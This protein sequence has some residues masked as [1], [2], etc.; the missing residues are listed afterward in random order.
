MP[1]KRV[2]D[3]RLLFQKNYITLYSATSMTSIRKCSVMRP[4]WLFFLCL[5]L[6]DLHSSLACLLI[7]KTTR[8]FHC[9]RFDFAVEINACTEGESGAFLVVE[10]HEVKDKLGRYK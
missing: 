8:V 1:S 9:F 4:H 6:P 2:Q 3:F 5:P 10:L 7:W